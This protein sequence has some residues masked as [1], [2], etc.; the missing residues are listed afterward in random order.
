M[1]SRVQSFFL[2][3]D[4]CGGEFGECDGGEEKREKKE[5]QI[6]IRIRIIIHSYNTS[7][8]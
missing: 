6:R 8:K 1:L 2:G 5:I 4:D 7:E 3:S